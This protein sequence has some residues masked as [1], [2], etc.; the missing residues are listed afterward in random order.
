VLLQKKS[1]DQDLCLLSA[2]KAALS[3]ETSGGSHGDRPPDA[4]PAA[5]GDRKALLPRRT[6]ARASREIDAMVHDTVLAAAEEGP[7]EVTAPTEARQSVD[8]N[9]DAEAEAGF[10]PVAPEGY[11]LFSGH[12]VYGVYGGGGH[13]S[14]GVGGGLGRGGAYSEAARQ[15]AWREEFKNVWKMSC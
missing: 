12:G 10:T 9:S 15:Q 4:A 14:H 13:G 3:R 11:G 6:S 2:A 7:A 8:V 5:D 1:R